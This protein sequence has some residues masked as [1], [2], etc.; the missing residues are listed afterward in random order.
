MKTFKELGLNT[1]IQQSLEE[2]GYI[3][4]TPI[5]EQAIPF[6]LESDQ[7]MIGLA[8]TGTGKTAA[9]GLPILQKLDKNKQLQAIILCPT[10]ELCLQ[11]S[12]EITNFAK[13]SVGVTLATVYGGARI[14]LQI[15]QLRAG[16][17]IVVGTPGR[18]HDLIRRKIL[19]LQTIRFVVLDEADEMLDLG[20]KD[21]LDAILAETPREKQTL[22][23]SATMSATIYSIAKKYMDEPKEISVGKKNVG[24]DKVVHQYYLVKPGQKYEAL[25]R[26][27]D[28]EPDIYGILFC[29]TRNETQEIADRLKEDRYSTEAL[30]GDVSQNMRT[31]IMDRFRQRKIQLLVATDVAARGIDVNDL[32]HVINYSLPDVSEIY[33]H[34]SGRTGRAQKSGVSLSILTTRELRKIKE[35]E[36][37]TG[38]TFEQKH[39]PT[40]QMICEKQ[41]LSLVDKMKSIEVDEKE[42]APFLPAVEERFKGMSRSE[43]LA[44][45]VSAEFNHFLSLYKDSKDIEAI[46]AG[47]QYENERG[48]RE[49]KERQPDENF[50]NA[51]INI[52]KKDGLDIKTLFGL[53]NSQ[54]EL[55]GA[56]V[57]K[58]KMSDTFT[59]FGIEKARQN[60]IAKSFRAS[61]FKGRPI[62]V[63]VVDGFEADRP[64]RNFS[65]KTYQGARKGNRKP[66]PFKGRR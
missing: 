16:A 57:G 28:S 43:L 1:H 25:R 46:S 12:K 21:E 32:T 9:F 66:S 34:R 5:Q 39:V 64:N 58:I 47:S 17:N 65:G 19:K 20:F 49:R 13:H 51:R 59:V 22:L 40:G 38:K 45:F 29:R 50:I 26:V 52:G 31:L 30:H 53:I 2:L 24:A 14:D 10:R 3:E 18:V 27:V 23:F 4:A 36:H 62:E 61:R 7:D 60:D 63:R 42:I 6:V 37:K 44:R 56:E 48:G 33:V 8:Q 54:R 11:I 41:L 15:Q 35:L 55:K